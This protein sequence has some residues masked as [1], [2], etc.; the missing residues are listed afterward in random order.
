MFLIKKLITVA[1]KNIIYMF[2]I[3]KSIAS[4]SKNLQTKKTKDTR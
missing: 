3:K 2:L 1:N 4:L